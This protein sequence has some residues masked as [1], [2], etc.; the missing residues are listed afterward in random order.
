MSSDACSETSTDWLGIW[1][2][3]HAVQAVLRAATM[4][5][6]PATPEDVVDTSLGIY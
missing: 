2:E 4:N 1:C 6:L 3:S 5:A